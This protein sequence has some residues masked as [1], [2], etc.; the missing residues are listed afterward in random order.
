MDFSKIP[1]FDDI[2][3]M[4]SYVHP[5]IL[6]NDTDIIFL[7]N[8]PFFFQKLNYNQFRSK[9]D[10]M[11]KNM[12]ICSFHPEAPFFFIITN[13]IINVGSIYRD[14][15][16]VCEDILSVRIWKNDKNVIYFCQFQESLYGNSSWSNSTTF[17]LRFFYQP[18]L[19]LLYV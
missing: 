16:P 8:K 7:T 14:D 12:P 2:N 17:Q 1:R 15:R 9:R 6:R 5:S 18:L 13:R 11:L 3:S 19:F 10:K 4:S